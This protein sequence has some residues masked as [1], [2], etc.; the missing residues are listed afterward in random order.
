MGVATYGDRL[1]ALNKF[2]GTLRVIDLSDLAWRPWQPYLLP[3]AVVASIASAGVM[4][5]GH[6]VL[7]RYVV[8]R[9]ENIRTRRKLPWALRKTGVVLPAFFPLALIVVVLPLAMLRL[10]PKAAPREVG[11]C[12][13]RGETVEL[14]V[15]EQYAYVIGSERGRGPVLWVVDLSEPASPRR[16]GD[17]LL[18]ETWGTVS[19]VAVAGKYVYLGNAHGL[20][21]VEVADP[22]AP[23]VVGC[24]QDSIRSSGEVPKA[25]AVAGHY[26]L[27]THGQRG[28]R[29]FDVSDPTSPQ[30]V[31]SYD[32]PL[33]P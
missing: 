11:C 24:Y 9:S 22:A 14:A 7:A 12:A 33:A 21:V 5:W 28:M 31:G 20:Q 27:V 16:V 26:A 32:S 2:N 23:K 10:V 8:R 30:P 1:V 18:S 17:C 25:I 13:L 15:A 4:F 29:V 3:L 19:A 6:R